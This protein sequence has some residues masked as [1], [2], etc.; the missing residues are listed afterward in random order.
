ML[1]LEKMKRC[2]LSTQASFDLNVVK[3]LDDAFS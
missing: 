2:W 1:G 3:N